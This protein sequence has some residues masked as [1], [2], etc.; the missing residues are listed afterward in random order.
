[1]RSVLAKI[2]AQDKKVQQA[3]SPYVN[4]IYVNE[5]IASVQDHLERYGLVCKPAERLSNGAKVLGLEVWGEDETIRWKRGSQ[6]EDVP[7]VLTRRTVFSFCGKLVGH[8]PI[9]GWLRVAS[10]FI[11]RKVNSLTT[12][13]DEVVSDE[14]LRLMMEDLMLRVKR[15]DPARGKWNV[16]GE[17]ATVWVDASSLAIGVII[18]VDGHTIED[19]SWLRLED[20]SHINMAE[21]D[22]VI[23]GVNLAL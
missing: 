5:D 21:L 11:K 14:E 7:N 10:S 17:E 20:A 3:P 22:A 6:L 2:L 23:K 4:D 9:C 12:S 15:N 16:D 18:Q 8:L 13:W 19:A 1:M